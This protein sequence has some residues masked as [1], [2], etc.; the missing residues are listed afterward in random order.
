MNVF[1]YNDD[2]CINGY[3][4][5]SEITMYSLGMAG[6]IRYQITAQAYVNMRDSNE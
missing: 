5:K 3:Y 4:T 1:I 6:F 2:D